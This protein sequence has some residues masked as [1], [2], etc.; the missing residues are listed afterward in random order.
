M[1]QLVVRLDGDAERALES[2]AAS[3]GVTRSEAARRAIILAERERVRARLRADAAAIAADP[4][5]TAE[6]RA[7][8]EEMAARRAW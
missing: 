3:A 2:L 5:E 4:A 6:A 1:S 8:S 7:L